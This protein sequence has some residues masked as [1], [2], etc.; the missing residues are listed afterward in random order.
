MIGER[1]IKLRT[2]EKT[3][4]CCALPL[5]AFQKTL[6]SEKVGRFLFGQ[7]HRIEIEKNVSNSVFL[8]SK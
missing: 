1:K 7:V 3:V 2:G 5:V 6:P 4:P 8:L